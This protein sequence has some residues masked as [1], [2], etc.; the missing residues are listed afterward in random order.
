MTNLVFSIDRWNDRHAVLEKSKITHTFFT[1]A[2]ASASFVVVGG[3]RSPLLIPSPALL[4]RISSLVQLFSVLVV[5]GESVV[6]SSV[7][8]IIISRPLSNLLK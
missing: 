1:L 6:A 4:S 8:V 7:A 5:G 3:D 2:L